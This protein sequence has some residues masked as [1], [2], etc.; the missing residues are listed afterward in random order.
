MK[1][2][3]YVLFGFL[4]MFLFNIDALAFSIKCEYK[5]VWPDNI[6]GVANNSGEYEAIEFKEFATVILSY[7]GSE[8]KIVVDR[9][10][11]LNVNFEYPEKVPISVFFDENGEPLCPTMYQGYLGE[12]GGI[13]G[14]FNKIYFIFSYSYA[15]VAVDNIE[16]TNVLNPYKINIDGEIELKE[17]YNNSKFCHYTNVNDDEGYKIFDTFS[18]T[19]KK[20]GDEVYFF[21]PVV[22]DGY[23]I[24]GINSRCFQKDYKDVAGCENFNYEKFECPK[25]LFVT[26]DNYNFVTIYPES[27]GDEENFNAEYDG[28]IQNSEYNAGFGVYLAYNS[29]NIRKVVLQKVGGDYQVSVSNKL[30]EIDKSGDYNDYKIA[31]DERND[32]EYPTYLYNDTTG[33]HFTDS[34]PVNYLNLYIYFEHLLK[35]PNGSETPFISTCQTII[36]D[37]FLEFL[38][39]NVLRI[40]YIGVPIILILLTSFDFAKVVF[41]NDKEGIQNAGKRFGKRVIVAVLIYLVPTILI[42]V[43]NTIGANQIDACVKQLEQLVEEESN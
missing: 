40:V 4:F 34:R 21:N 8:P 13:L 6:E 1:Y 15:R 17:D 37:G 41:I 10:F 24:Y 31:I 27:I 35:N 42:F 28:I 25:T 19:I 5:V 2:L 18:F 38:N 22:N 43:S 39:N 3:K 12:P 23:Y 20:N 16:K 36:G 33:W 32:A 11:D 26:Q 7:D 14:W 29:T 9:P 30:Y